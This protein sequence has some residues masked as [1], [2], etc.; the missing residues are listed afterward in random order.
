[1]LRQSRRLLVSALALLAVGP[2]IAQQNTAVETTAAPETELVPGFI[3][4]FDVDRSDRMTVPVS[5]NGSV[6]Y[7]FIVD[8]GAER[9][10][11]A[12]DLAKTLKLEQGPQLKL[13]TITGT[14]FADS[15]MIENL[16]MNTIN[17]ELIEAPGLERSN[18]GAYGLLGIDSLED[19]KVLLDFRNTK[20]DVLPSKRKSKLGRLE[21]GM[22][23]VT[24]KRKAGR[25]I[26]SDAEVGGVKVDI[27]LDTGAQTSMGNYALRDRLRK[28]DMRFDYVPVRMRSVTGEILEGD[29][30]QVRD[31]AIGGVTISD[32]PVTFADNYAF[33]ALK[34]ER[35]PAILLGMD[36]MKLFD[37]VLVDFSN[38]RVGFDLP[39]GAGKRNGIQLAMN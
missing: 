8:T 23:V 14:A 32:L 24:A 25:M 34:L 19:H 30:T 15:Y 1:M 4:E 33:K 18:L 11:I 37:R 39:K 13:A 5:I 36:A 26:L 2:A 22:I 35:K 9:T 6:T 28:R 10:V 29:F 17:V 7:P 27:I 20:M 16:T 12:N 31:I 3:Q 38:R 21:K